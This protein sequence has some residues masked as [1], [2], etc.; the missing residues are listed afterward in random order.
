VVLD[1]R[2]VVS[3]LVTNAIRHAPG[4]CG[5]TL[6]LI[7]EELVITVWDTSAEEPVFKRPDRHRVGGHGLHLVRAASTKVTVTPRAQGKQVTARLRV[8][9]LRGGSTTKDRTVLFS[10]L[11]GRTRQRD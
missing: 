8:T 4:P 10:P 2:L 5:L 11:P 6:H 3:E 7:G 9:R 1:A